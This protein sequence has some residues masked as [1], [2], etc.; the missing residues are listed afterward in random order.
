M[1][2]GDKLANKKKKKKTGA[3]NGGAENQHFRGLAAAKAT[4]SAARCCDLRGGQRKSNCDIVL[5]LG[6]ATQCNSAQ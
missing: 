1:E 2:K 6:I 3:E 5:W 4:A